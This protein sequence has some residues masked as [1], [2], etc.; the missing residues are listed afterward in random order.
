MTSFSTRF[1]RATS[2]GSTCVLGEGLVVRLVGII[3][4]VGLLGPMTSG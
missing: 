1:G 4:L 3:G 2:L